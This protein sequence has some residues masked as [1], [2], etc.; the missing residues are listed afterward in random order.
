MINNYYDAIATLGLA[1]GASKN[2]V[3]AAFRSLSKKYHPDLYKG[4]NGESFKRINQAY[5]YLKRNNYSQP[6]SYTYQQSTTTGYQETEKSAHSRRRD[7]YSE[8][9]KRKKK[10]I[11]RA[12]KKRAGSQKGFNFKDRQEIQAVC[13]RGA[14][15]KLLFTIRLFNANRRECLETRYSSSC[16]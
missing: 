1:E 8:E 10:K 7:Y 3:R 6:I 15:I 2:E 14:G 4:D 5:Q 12:K 13:I 16:S 11:P 9:R